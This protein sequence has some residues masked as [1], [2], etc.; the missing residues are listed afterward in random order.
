[1]RPALLPFLPFCA[2]S[3]LF[4]GGLACAAPASFTAD[5]GQ[6]VCNTAGPQAAT[7]SGACKDGLADGA[8]VATWTDGTTPNKLD[9]KL[10]HGEVIDTATL[11]Y[12]EHTYI[13]TFAHFAPHGQGFYK[14][15]DGSMYEGGIDHGKYSGPGIFQAVDRSRY[16]GMWVDGDR[17]GQGQAT[18]ALGG[19]YDGHWRHN[20]FDGAGSIVYVGGRK[21]TGQFKDGQVAGLPPL[22][23]IEE[24]T[25]RINN[26][27]THVG[28]L[29]PRQTATSPVSGARW[30]ELSDGERRIVKSRYKALEAGDEPPYPIEG[31]RPLF[32]A[33]TKVSHVDWSF[34][35]PVRMHVLVGADGK[36][37]SVTTVGK[38]PPE[39]GKYLGSILMIT[40]YKPAVCHGQPCDMIY[41]L[42]MNFEHKL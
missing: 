21:Y 28:S 31:M 10:A 40:T 33:L 41:P 32:A 23:A 38:L 34:V 4:A 17:E 1:M 12:G 26:T 27:E 11:I 42:V 15:P 39:A 5:K 36:P 19:S 16:E 37:K 30:A 18:F 6:L 14:Y 24:H 7:W 13:G 20:Q 25:F 29:I 3:L 8:G 35:G 22:P 9:G 2:L